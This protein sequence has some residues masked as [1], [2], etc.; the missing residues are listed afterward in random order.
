MDSNRNNEAEFLSLLFFF[1][2]SSPFCARLL[3]RLLSTLICLISRVFLTLLRLARECEQLPV[4]NDHK[5]ITVIVEIKLSR[6]DN[7]DAFATEQGRRLEGNRLRAQRVTSRI[8]SASSSLVFRR[9]RLHP[10]RIRTGDS[11]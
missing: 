6:H 1:F 7:S 11:C 9:P 8:L 3:D 10:S 2:S 5:A 4:I